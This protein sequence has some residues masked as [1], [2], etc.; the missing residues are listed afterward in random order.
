MNPDPPDAD[1]DRTQFGRPPL[2]A[3]EHIRRGTYRADRHAAA[4]DDDV[5]AV[6][7]ARVLA[8]LPRDAKQLAVALLDTFRGWNPAMLITLRMYV[9]SCDR[10]ARL[11]DARTVHVTRLHAELR[12][13]LEL[14]Q[15]LG[16][17]L[18]QQEP[19]DA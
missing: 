1:P 10:V 11:Q 9:L 7:R 3:D 6:D 12:I 15:V 4:G 19:A 2:S 16:L 18:P 8:K 17:E 14:L 13:N 5:S